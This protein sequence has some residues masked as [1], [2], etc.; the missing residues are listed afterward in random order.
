MPT[1][2]PPP[3]RR[4]AFTPDSSR[5]CSAG[6]DKIVQ[7]WNLGGISRDIRRV[8]L[9]ERTI[10]W[11]VARGLRGSIYAL[12]IAPNDG[13]L[14]FGGYGAM[15]SLGEI[16]LVNPVS[17]NLS[18][19]LEGHRQTVCSLSFS[20]DGQ[21]LASQD[22]GGQAML[23]QRGPMEAQDALRAGRKDLR[24]GNSRPDCPAAQTAADRFRR[25]GPRRA[26]GLRGRG[27]ARSA[28]LA[29]HGG[30]R[31]Q[32]PGF[33]H[34]LDTIHYG[35]VSALAASPD[36]ARLA[37]ADLEGNLYLWDLAS[38]RAERLETAAPVVSLAF[39]PDGN[40]AGGRHVGCS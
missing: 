30:Q 12:S 15:G 20:A 32:R 31:R 35:M 6:L 33:P 40:T 2:T 4:L 19:V 7:V 28:S 34:V 8:Y 5:L 27:D 21:W 16:L 18:K 24:P 37:S 14:A 13:L 39:S 11:Q 10:R 38:G 3:S 36:G 26:A 1:G 23:W 9:R 25:Q 22:T 29:T 17:G